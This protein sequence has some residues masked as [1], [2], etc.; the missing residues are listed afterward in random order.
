MI[1]LLG[2][3]PNKIAIAASG[4]PDSMATLDFLSRSKRDILALHFNH[5]TKHAYKAE[6]LVADYCEDK[7]IPCVIGNISRD[8]YKSE[9]QEEYWRNERY[10]FFSN[11]YDYKIITCHHL[12]DAVETWIFTSLNGTSMLIP[13]KR[14][15]FLRPLLST[16]KSRLVSWCD[17]KKVPYIVDPSNSDTKYMRN[18][19]RHVLLP[20]A[21][22]VNPGLYKVVRKKVLKAYNET[23]DII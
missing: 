8:K 20:N 5:G 9:S 6:R 23:M 19:I 17:R 3:I 16:R 14:D 22:I 15:N 10:A 11:Y 7:D 2:S 21:L 13:Y 12:D 18:F 4:G 1:K